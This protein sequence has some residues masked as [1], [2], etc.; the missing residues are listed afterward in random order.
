MFDYISTFFAVLALDLVYTYYLRAVAEN[1]VLT[2]SFWSVACYL[3]ASV[4]VINYTAN[5]ALLV[6]ALLGAFCGTYLGMKLKIGK[7]QDE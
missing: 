1:R 3:G 2:A 7:T 5:H 6:P 4:A